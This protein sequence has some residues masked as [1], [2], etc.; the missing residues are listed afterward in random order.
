MQA[1]LDPNQEQPLPGLILI[2]TDASPAAA[3]AVEVGLELAAA[4]ASNVVFVHFSAAAR[5]L[6]DAHPEAGPSQA[7]IEAADPVLRA[8]ADAARVRAIQ[9]TLKLHGAEHAAGD[10]A[11]ALAG[12]ASGL[13]ASMIVLGTRGHGAIAS[14]V[15]GSVSRTLLSFSSV[16]V[17]VVHPGDDQARSVD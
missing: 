13:D 1:E 6:F 2:A 15:L 7:E 9:F 17:V 16:P 11:A 5:P 14:A 8:A 12:M 3:K 10:I 4:R